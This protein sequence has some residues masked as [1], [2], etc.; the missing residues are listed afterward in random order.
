MDKRLQEI[1]NK[2]IKSAEN[3]LNFYFNDTLFKTV[4]NIL[5]KELNSESFYDDLIFSMKQETFTNE[6]KIVLSEIILST[7]GIPN[8]VYSYIINSCRYPVVFL[9]FLKNRS[10]NNSNLCD[11]YE[12]YISAYSSEGDRI[13]KMIKSSSIPQKTVDYIAKLVAN[14]FIENGV[15]PSSTGLVFIENTKDMDII[16]SILDCY[17]YTD[18]Y[19]ISSI[20]NNHNL[21][22]ELR[23]RALCSDYE[24]SHIEFFNDNVRNEIFQTCI[25]TAFPNEAEYEIS[26]QDEN[27]ALFCLSKMVKFLDEKQYT[28]LLNKIFA[29]MEKYKF[30]ENVLNPA[31]AASE[32]MY[33]NF[34]KYADNYI[35]NHIIKSFPANSLTEFLSINEN[36]KSSEYVLLAY[37]T[38]VIANETGETKFHKNCNNI[39]NLQFFAL[40]NIISHSENISQKAFDLMLSAQNEDIQDL[41]F[42]F[43][44][45]TEKHYNQIAL[46]TIFPEIKFKAI[47][48][49]EIRKRYE[50]LPTFEKQAFEKTGGL[51]NS[52]IFR[53]PGLVMS[54]KKHIHQYISY[55]KENLLEPDIVDVLTELSNCFKTSQ[56]I[57]MTGKLDEITSYNERIRDVIDAIDSD[58]DTF[59]RV[60]KYKNSKDEMSADDILFCAEYEIN[61][62]LD[63]S[64]TLAN[65]YR[66]RFA[67]DKII[68][69]AEM[70]LEKI[71]SSPEVSITNNIDENFSDILEDL[72]KE[73]PCIK[74]N[75]EASSEIKFLDE[76]LENLER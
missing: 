65:F 41:L 67:C 55:F 40:K 54:N 56:T 29:N 45:L 35:G 8:H 64:K 48:F 36:L 27:T 31:V 25:D 5:S 60:F 21:T 26:E 76:Y 70:K 53:K 10:A 13:G 59:K 19:V 30:E 22:D 33:I 1:L 38:R 37:T 6:A 15:V 50:R 34:L 24:I 14:D 75:I 43:E 66:N 39:S 7:E 2:E 11:L 20:I 72:P 18:G 51:I 16:S 23:E 42:S 61:K 47:L 58:I 74:D 73:K 44:N 49:N 71:K 17:S 62:K 69:D 28:I 52:Y 68:E 32:K 9:S 63:G 4:K 46:K 3:E 12:K 57:A